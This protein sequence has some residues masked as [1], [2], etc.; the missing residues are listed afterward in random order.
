MSTSWV[1]INAPYTGGGNSGQNVFQG[2]F[3]KCPD[4]ATAYSCTN[5]NNGVSFYF[6]DYGHQ[7]GTCGNWYDTGQQKAPMGNAGPGSLVYSISKGSTS[8]D[9]TIAGSLQ[10]SESIYNIETCWGRL[11]NEAEYQNETWDLN[12]QNAG[13]VSTHQAYS[14][15][16]VQYNGSWHTVS[17]SYPRTCDANSNPT[18]WQCNVASNG[19]TFYEYDTRAP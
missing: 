16:Q 5:W 13:T 17:W 8:Y 11:A 19:N 3:I 2:G 14:T 7:N 10:K 1:M 12:D 9:F 15:V 6:W 4:P 18:Y